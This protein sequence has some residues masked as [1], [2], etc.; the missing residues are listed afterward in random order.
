MKLQIIKSNEHNKIISSQ[1]IAKKIKAELDHKVEQAKQQ[2]QDLIADAQEQSHNLRQQAYHDAYSHAYEHTVNEMLASKLVKQTLITS[3]IPFFESII[4]QLYHNMI[5]VLDVPARVNK[6]LHD[7]ITSLLRANEVT[8]IIHPD[9]LIGTKASFQRSDNP[10]I[11]NLFFKVDE[12]IEPS[13]FVIQTKDITI[14]ADNESQHHLLNQVLERAKQQMN[15][16][17][18]QQ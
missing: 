12:N 18:H 7:E 9:A 5:G 2:A 3:A 17:I 16:A 8:I 13:E 1:Q 15:Q 4:K 14:V 6:V 10:L 11:K